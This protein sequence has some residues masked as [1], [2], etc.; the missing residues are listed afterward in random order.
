MKGRRFNKIVFDE[1][2][3]EPEKFAEKYF[4]NIEGS[5]VTKK[6]TDFYKAVYKLKEAKVK[7]LTVKE[8]VRN[9]ILDFSVRT[10][11]RYGISNYAIEHAHRE[12]QLSG[13]RKLR[14]LRAEYDDAMYNHTSEYYYEKAYEIKGNRYLFS[15]NFYEWL[16]YNYI[17]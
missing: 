9:L 8:A 13:L 10:V 12:H 5:K 7:K 6:G 4:T 15:R 16:R 3:N 14:E 17:A 1:I 2:I 11:I